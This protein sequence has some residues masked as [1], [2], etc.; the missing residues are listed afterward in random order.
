MPNPQE[1]IAQVRKKFEAGM[2]NVLGTRR[3]GGADSGF[4]RA[5]VESVTIA[6]RYC[7]E[8]EISRN[9]THGRIADP[10]GHIEL[11]VPYDG[12]DFFTRQACA[13]VSAQDD[14][15]FDD[16]LIGHLALNNYSGTNLGEVLSLSGS[17]GAVPIRVPVAG[18]GGPDALDSD[19][20]ACVISYDY[21]PNPELPKVIPIEVRVELIDPDTVDLA[22]LIEA[23]ST[24][25]K[26][27]EHIPNR[28]TQQVSFRQCLW[29]SLSVSISLPTRPSKELK[30][31]VKRVSLDWPTI[32]S[33][34]A[35]HVTVD[36]HVS[37]RITYNP[38]KRSIEWS[39]VPM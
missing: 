4:V 18:A 2:R 3:G 29:L 25:D 27:I 23:V 12:H 35:L 14:Q 26:K 20:Q 37:E 34:Q 19:E 17:Y 24:D 39:D 30:P 38:V 28:I 22:S 6:E 5:E 32:T 7:Y 13:D 11:T 1:R 21:A 31:V 10:T 15:G 36:Q 8:Q 33:L 16:A 9:P